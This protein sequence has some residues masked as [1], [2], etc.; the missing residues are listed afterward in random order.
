MEQ[1]MDTQRNKVILMAMVLKI[2][3]SFFVI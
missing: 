2:A 1:N 3:A